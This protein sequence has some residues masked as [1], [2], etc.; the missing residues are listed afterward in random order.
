MDGSPAGMIT[1]VTGLAPKSSPG[2]RV[3]STDSLR[4]RFLNQESPW[5]SHTLI[6][7]VSVSCETRN[8]GTGRGAPCSDDWGLLGT[9]LNRGES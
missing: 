3:P 1:R 5:C 2:P 9:S 4:K 6:P 8:W 7:V